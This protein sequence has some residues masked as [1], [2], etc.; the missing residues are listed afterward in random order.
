MHK[1]DRSIV[2]IKQVQTKILFMRGQKVILDS[3]LAAL[4]GVPTKGLNEQIKRN[5]ER[6]PPD[7]MFQLTAEEVEGLRSQIA[8]SNKEH[9]GG[10]L[11][12]I[13][14]YVSRISYVK[15]AQPEYSTG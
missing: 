11:M 10:G 5:Q 9:G 15:T 1:N 3:D 12:R 13:A 8:T 2:L 6:F 7:F 4:Y 14:L